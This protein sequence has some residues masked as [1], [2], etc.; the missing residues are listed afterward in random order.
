MKL[1]AF[2]CRAGVLVSPDC[3][4]ASAEAE[5]LY[6]P[7]SFLG[8]LDSEGLP[9]SVQAL[10]AH[11]VEAHWFAFLESSLVASFPL[12]ALIAPPPP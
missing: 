12:Q 3:L 10:V 7:V 11:D 1:N 2:S 9:A 5:H 6:G 4:L 8:T